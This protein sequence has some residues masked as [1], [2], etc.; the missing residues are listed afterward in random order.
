MR[1]VDEIGMDELKELLIK[2]W[3]THDGMWFYQCVLALGIEQTNRLNKGAIKA[4]AEIE[5]NRAKKILGI[6]K[7]RIDTFEELRDFLYGAFGLSVGDFMSGTFSFPEQDMMRWEVGDQGCFAYRGMK[8]MGVIDR[9][10]CGVLY[11]V[12]CWIENLG[13]RYSV[14]PEISGCLF[15]SNGKCA[16]DVKFSFS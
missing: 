15:H 5:T 4:L 1:R 12:L 14:S 7:D 3:M 10:Q 8:R 16:G 11:R 9:Y 6:E 2:N 13:V